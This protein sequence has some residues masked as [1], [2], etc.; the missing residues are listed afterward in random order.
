MFWDIP[1]FRFNQEIEN[2]AKS[3]N[4]WSVNKK[5]LKEERERERKQGCTNTHK[6]TVGAGVAQAEQ[7]KVGELRQL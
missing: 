5:K 6:L 3:I 4:K 1:T 2:S 7:G